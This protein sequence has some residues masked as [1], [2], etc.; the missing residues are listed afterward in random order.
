MQADVFAEIPFV[1]V[2]NTLELRGA[3]HGSA[4]ECTVHSSPIPQIA[5]QFQLAQKR[6]Y[7]IQDDDARLLCH[8]QFQP[9]RID[10]FPAA[11]TAYS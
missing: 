4:I 5:P 1:R 10:A 2:S 7:W 11:A 6:F 9:G 8:I 3:I